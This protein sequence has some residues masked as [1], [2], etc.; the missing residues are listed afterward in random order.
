MDKAKL[1]LHMELIVDKNSE[2]MID[3]FVTNEWPADLLMSVS[4]EMS[5][6]IADYYRERK[7]S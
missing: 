3:K 2:V 6:K 7:S 5:K 4:A 1:T